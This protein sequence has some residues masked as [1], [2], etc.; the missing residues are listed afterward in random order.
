MAT[1]MSKK[2]YYVCESSYVAQPIIENGL[3][4]MKTQR[5]RTK[6]KKAIG[7]AA[8]LATNLIRLVS[9]RSFVASSSVCVRVSFCV[10]LQCYLHCCYSRSPVAPQYFHLYNTLSLSLILQQA[11]IRFWLFSFR[12]MRLDFFIWLSFQPLA[13]VPKHSLFLIIAIILWIPLCLFSSSSLFFFHFLCTFSD[14]SLN[15]NLCSLPSFSIYCEHNGSKICCWFLFL[16]YFWCVCNR[17]AASNIP[18]AYDS[19]IAR[20]YCDSIFNFYEHFAEIYHW[21]QGIIQNVKSTNFVNWKSFPIQHKT[22]IQPLSIP[23][24]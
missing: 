14:Y 19:E 1:G 23:K 18:I 12:W 4:E 3:D 9:Y 22:K 21:G 15:N 17:M 2:A 10:C 6:K 20:C 7:N 16:L 13:L 11:T 24:L 8:T 5:K